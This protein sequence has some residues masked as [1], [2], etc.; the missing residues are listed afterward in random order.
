MESIATINAKKTQEESKQI[1]EQLNQLKM[2][3]PVLKPEEK[4]VFHGSKG[5][6]QWRAPICTHKSTK[7]ARGKDKSYVSKTQTEYKDQPDVLA[8]KIKVLAQMIRDS[9]LCVAYTGAGISTGA[10][11]NDYASAHKP[12]NAITNFRMARPTPAHHAIT[13]LIKDGKIMHWCQQNHDGLA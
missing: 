4:Q 11:I 5:S 13:G 8:A 2:Q 3:Q 6:S 1:V 9:Q 12:K 10:G 7:I